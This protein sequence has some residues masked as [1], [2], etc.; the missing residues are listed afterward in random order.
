MMAKSFAD[1]HYIELPEELI[2]I[3][4]EAEK[5]LKK[6]KPFEKGSTPLYNQKGDGGSDGGGDHGGKRY[7]RGGDAGKD[8]G[9]HI[10]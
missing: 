3:S 2:K 1:Y 7:D 4:K 8:G 9:R 10:V 5:N 6:V